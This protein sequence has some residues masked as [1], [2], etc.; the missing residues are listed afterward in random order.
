MGEKQYTHEEFENARRFLEG[1]S[2][3]QDN[4]LDKDDADAVTE[5]FWDLVD[6]PIPSNDIL[7]IA[8]EL[9]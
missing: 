2:I 8:E 5:A 4:G 3:L 6:L 1:I 7:K 9:M